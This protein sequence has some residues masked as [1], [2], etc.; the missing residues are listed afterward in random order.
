MIY[1]GSS[2]TGPLIFT[3]FHISNLTVF[4]LNLTNP[5]QGSTGRVSRSALPQGV[6][7]SSISPLRLEM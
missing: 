2:F 3:R 6:P 1:A 4:K 7:L 5:E